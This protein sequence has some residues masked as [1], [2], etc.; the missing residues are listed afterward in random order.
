MRHFGTRIDT[1]TVVSK[2]TLLKLGLDNGVRL[3]PSKIRHCD[4]WSLVETDTAFR[5]GKISQRQLRVLIDVASSDTNL[6][7]TSE[8]DTRL[9]GS[10]LHGITHGTLWAEVRQKIVSCA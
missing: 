7:T 5:T 10:E 8:I 9:G 4:E 6:M 3:P 1:L 2:L